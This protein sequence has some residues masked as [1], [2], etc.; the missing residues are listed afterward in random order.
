MV[1]MCE[2]HFEVFTQL[3]ALVEYVSSAIWWFRYMILHG[4]FPHSQG[5][6]HQVMVQWAALGCL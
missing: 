1:N 2:T 4:H 3:L 5:Q 6:R